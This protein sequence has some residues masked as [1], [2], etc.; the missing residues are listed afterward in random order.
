MNSEFQEYLSNLLNENII[1]IRSVA[2]GDISESYKITT[3]HD[4]YFLKIN[5]ESKLKMFQTEANALKQINKTKTI[6]TPKVITCNTFE[7]KAFLLMEFIESKSPSPDDFKTLGFQL[8]A[9]HKCSSDYF[10]LEQDNFIGTLL[11]SNKQSIS[12]SHFYLHERLQPQLELAK[13]N[14]LISENE[15]PLLEQ[16]EEKLQPLFNNL[17]PSLLHGDLWS[18]NYFISKKGIPYIIDPAM[19]YGHCEVDIAMTKLFDGFG[20]DFYK[21]YRSIHLEDNYT[22]SRIEIYQL[23]YLLVHLNLFGIS[24][25]GSVSRILK[26]HF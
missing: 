3:S 8:A 15:C 11:Q 4:N 13:K 17:S 10:G 7:N 1:N 25:Y 16:M 23:Y 20:S 5:Q 21:T 18:G 14:H 12:W 9:L 26:R 22:A 19:Y 6:K 2:G 24:Y